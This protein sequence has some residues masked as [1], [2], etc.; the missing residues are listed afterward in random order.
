MTAAN[1]TPRSVYD[2]RWSHDDFL[3]LIVAEAIEHR[4]AD[5]WYLNTNMPCTVS[6]GGGGRLAQILHFR[7]QGRP[8]RAASRTEDPHIHAQGRRPDRSDVSTIIDHCIVLIGH[9]VTPRRSWCHMRC[10][11]R[12]E[13][14]NRL[15][16]LVLEAPRC[17]KEHATHVR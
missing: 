17:W 6:G 11:S 13:A 16:H 3:S 14:S 8:S 15:L 1:R 4:D 9:P 7:T 2:R 10:A 12:R 5:G